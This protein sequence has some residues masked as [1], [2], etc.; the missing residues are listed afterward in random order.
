MN[1]TMT[2]KKKVCNG[3]DV[4][5]GQNEIEL[6]TKNENTSND[7]SLTHMATHSF[8]MFDMLFSIVACYLPD[9]H[10]GLPST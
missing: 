3:T 10:L 9:A 1:S 5:N 4:E 2:R 7:Y 6:W 8:V